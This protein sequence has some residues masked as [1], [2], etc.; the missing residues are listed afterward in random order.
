MQLL[1]SR[2]KLD[3]AE[4]LLDQIRKGSKD[5]HN[6]RASNKGPKVDG[7]HGRNGSSKGSPPLVGSS[8]KKA[9]IVLTPS[10][11]KKVALR[12]QPKLPTSG[13]IHSGR[14]Q[15]S[16][17]SERPSGVWR[18]CNHFVENLTTTKANFVSIN[19]VFLYISLQEHLLNMNQSQ[20]LMC[21]SL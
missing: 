5:T 13:Q 16:M 4:T 14:N 19:H 18:I 20:A 21:L 2:A 6:E 15:D 3:E 8:A 12:E 17:Y 9:G 11:S 1:E 7:S 10:Q